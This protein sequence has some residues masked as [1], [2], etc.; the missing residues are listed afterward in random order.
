MNF[1]KLSWTVISDRQ[2]QKDLNNNG[3]CLIHEPAGSKSV[4]SAQLLQGLSYFLFVLWSFKVVIL[5]LDVFYKMGM[6]FYIL[7]L[8]QFSLTS[9]KFYFPI[10][11]YI[12]KFNELR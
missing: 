3:V 9:S 7:W 8:P 10:L 4:C 2:Q 1:M 5:P 6:P 11:L 12:Q